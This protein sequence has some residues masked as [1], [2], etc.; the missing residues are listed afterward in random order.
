[1]RAIAKD[2]L[3]SF[4]LLD[5]VNRMRWT[6]WDYM[7]PARQAL[8]KRGWLRWEP[9]VPIEGFTASCKL[10]IQVLQ[11]HNHEFGAYLEF[12]VSRGTSMVCMYKELREA[13][14]GNVPIIGF[15]SFEG[16]PQEAAKQGWKPGEFASTEKATRRYL[17][18]NGVKL[19][20]VSLVKGWFKDTL[21]AE[22]LR[23]FNLVKASLILIDCDIYTAS[24]EAMWFC[25][26]LIDDQA[27]IIFDDW[28]WRADLNQ[29][30][31][32]E[33]YTEFLEAFPHFD[34]RSLPAYLPQARI[35]HVRRKA[36]M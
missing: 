6:I 11:D 14:L 3:Q 17:Q 4:G 29:I 18:E 8:L 24:K 32:R 33:V 5:P 31:Q 35:F 20:E 13:G 21:T 25:E 15:D 34:S 1:M 10:A 19:D 12:G 36:E 30:G 27:I 26:P 7:Q 28:G 16:L 22:S 23:Q 9:L 2:I